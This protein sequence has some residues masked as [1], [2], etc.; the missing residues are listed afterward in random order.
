[1][2]N[3]V[4]NTAWKGGIYGKDEEILVMTRKRFDIDEDEEVESSNLVRISDVA[5]RFKKFAQNFD[6]NRIRI[7]IDEID[8]KV[9]ITTGMMVG[10]LGAPGAGKT[11]LSNAF[12]ENLS[13]NNE[14]TVYFSLDMFDNLLFTRL[15]QKYSSY[16]MTKII[17][18]FQKNELDQELILAVS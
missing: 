16:D 5:E 2:I 8:S 18:M 17:E 11:T 7:G 3:T 9:T 12:I 14:S 4:Y 6:K 1:M 13:K 15:L 10:L